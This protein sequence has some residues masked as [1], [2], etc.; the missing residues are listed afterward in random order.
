MKEGRK[1]SGKKGSKREGA[2]GGNKNEGSNDASSLMLLPDPA[3]GQQQH[4][5]MRRYGHILTDQRCAC[6]RHGML[7]FRL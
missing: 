3:V 1:V 6:W 4:P 2:K 7:S 5:K